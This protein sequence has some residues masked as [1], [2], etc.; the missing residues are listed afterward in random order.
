MTAATIVSVIFINKTMKAQSAQRNTPIT[1]SRCWPS[2]CRILRYTLSA[3]HRGKKKVNSDNMVMVMLDWSDSLSV[4]SKEWK[5]LQ[6]LDTISLGIFSQPKMLTRQIHNLQWL[7]HLWSDV[8]VGHTWD[9]QTADTRAVLL[10][11]TA[12]VDDK[13]WLFPFSTSF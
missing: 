6:L 5:S 8:V 3:K 7:F 2:S 13:W 1:H 9:F 10:V 12:R 11:V 4:L